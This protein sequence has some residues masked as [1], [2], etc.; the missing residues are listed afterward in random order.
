MIAA[1]R[2]SARRDS[3]IFQKR[4]FCMRRTSSRSW[5]FTPIMSAAGRPCLVI[6]TRSRP[7]SPSS[8][9][10]G[11][12]PPPALRG[13][14]ATSGRGSRSLLRSPR[15]CLREGPCDLSFQ[16]ARASSTECSR[17]CGNEVHVV[18]VSVRT[19]RHEP[20]EARDD[21]TLGE[22]K[23]VHIESARHAVSKVHP[24]EEAPAVGPWHE[25][26]RF[27][28]QAPV[29]SAEEPVDLEPRVVQATTVAV[30]GVQV[31]RPI[32]VARPIWAVRARC[33]PT[34]PPLVTTPPPA[35]QA[36]RPL[37]SEVLAAVRS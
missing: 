14:L 1:R 32:C 15:R 21:H 23:D 37:R 20:A 4:G 12:T 29:L 35:P 5:P 24:Q 22:A 6:N 33:P 30:E 36:C 3:I 11:A 27:G 19:L 13:F 26:R 7:T 17:H 10:R 18:A 2:L 31:V 16:A 25:V 28:L 8:F 9:T 34:T